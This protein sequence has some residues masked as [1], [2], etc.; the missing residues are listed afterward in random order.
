LL[1]VFSNDMW[2]FVLPLMGWM[3]T[4][5]DLSTWNSL[6]TVEKIKSSG[7]HPTV[8]ESIKE[9]AVGY[10]LSAIL[11]ILFLV[12]G[13]FL[14]FGTGESVPKGAA[15]F[16]AFVV[17]LYAISLGDW[18]TLIVG[19]A[20]FSIMFSTF[21]TILDG[22]SRALG[23]ALPLLSTKF[24]KSSRIENIT[25]AVLAFGG[26]SLIIAFENNPDGFRLLINTATTL[27]FI[28]A[29]VIAVLNYRLVMKD[30]IGEQNSPGVLLKIMSFLGVLYLFAFLIW[31]LL[32]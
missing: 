23:T 12:I 30:K 9:F 5:L 11:A 15:A 25:I 13:A 24:V 28:V 22:Y 26:L 1:P 14:V 2:A 29:P 7:Y 6:W 4:A 16:S 17:D 3:P 8:K 10:W 31:F 18:A 21:I 27:S 19:A 20:A 32:F